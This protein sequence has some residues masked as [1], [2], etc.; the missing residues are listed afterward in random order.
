MSKNQPAS[1]DAPTLCEPASTSPEAC[2][3]AGFKLPLRF[4]NYELIEEVARGGMGIVFR[5]NQCDLKRTVAIKMV[6]DGGFAHAD[7]IQRFLAEAESAA[8]LDHPGIV[9]IY[10]VGECQGRHFFSMAF[11][12]GQSLSQ[13]LSDGPLSAELAATLLADVAEA[14]HYAHNQGVIHRDLKPGNVL[15][16]QLGRPRVTD[17]GVAKSATT[18]RGLTIQGELLG[19]PGYMPPEQAHGDTD[20][21]DATSDVYSLGAILY[22]VLTGRPP[23]QSASQ[24]DTLHQVIHDEVIPP[25][26]L[27]SQVPADLETITLKCLEKQQSRR[28]QSAAE[29]AAELHAFL[30]GEPIKAR[31]PGL[32]RRCATWIQQNF[33]VASMSG[34]TSIA[35]V[36]GMLGLAM[37]CRM[38]M[39]KNDDLSAQIVEM[40]DRAD[41]NSLLIAMAGGQRADLARL[42]RLAD[43]ERLSLLANQV[44]V[45]DRQLAIILALQ[46]CERLHEGRD[47]IDELPAPRTLRKLLGDS[48]S[49]AYA[50]LLAAAKKAATRKLTDDEEQK[51]LV[52]IGRE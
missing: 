2:S 27:N 36:M 6:I 8:N 15:L 52:H 19:T 3:D 12:D 35:L 49:L 40:K 24:I 9:P 48:D 11:I 50:E 23:F 22:A 7:D 5:A 45:N 25:G 20:K 1:L 51:Y 4:G 31:P 33:L 42:W 28:Y 37:R 10:E 14:I 41:Q 43:S 34:V 16:D 44:A 46:A 47:P 39:N 18:D 17:F 13:R 26:R 29:V 38:E 32:V 21:I 30:A